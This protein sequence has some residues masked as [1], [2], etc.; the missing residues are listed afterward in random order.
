MRIL[1]VNRNDSGQRLDKFLTKAVKGLPQSMMY[2]YIRTKKI[3]RNR[4]RTEPYV[5]L[6]EGDEI[7]LF[8]REE[9]F[10]APE[11]DTGALSRMAPKLDIVYEDEHI[12]LVHKRPGVLVHEDDAAEDNTLIMHIKAYLTQKGE[13]DPESEQSFVP[14]LC[15]RIDRNTGGIVIAAKD[16]SALR[17]MNERIRN[18][19]IRKFYYCLA[20]GKM[21][22]EADTLTG[23]L[24]KDSKNNQVEVTDGAKPGSKNIIT[25][26]RVLGFH[27]GV[28]LLEVEL[29]T[30]RTHQIRAHLAHIGHPLVGDGKYGVNR[31]D[32]EKG[33]KY[34]ALYAY[35]L[36]FDFRDPN[37]PLGYLRGKEIRLPEEDIW[38]WRDFEDRK[39]QARASE[40]NGFSVADAGEGGKKSSEKARGRGEKGEIGERKEAPH[41]RSSTGKP[42][43]NTRERKAVSSTGAAKG[44]R[45]VEKKQSGAAEHTGKP[46][47]AGDAGRKPYGSHNRKPVRADSGKNGRRAVTDGKSPGGKTPGKT[48]KKN[49]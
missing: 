44:T 32:R 40:N 20:H 6:E 23:F 4:A 5:M 7:Q 11:K 15:N 37:G 43:V 35:R 42:Y 38:F 24:R 1:K 41:D 29:V 9:F 47:R 48:G 2:K 33:Y 17:E 10:E 34:Q 36:I 16:A 30:G 45:D 28:S 39:E 26:Y 18:D 3:K 25:K 12:L 27:D 14:A 19:E 49:R 31:G 8:I 22:K 13:Y 21:P 46:P